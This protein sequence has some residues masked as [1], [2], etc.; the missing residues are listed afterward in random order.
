MITLSIT[1]FILWL[2]LVA[3]AAGS[4]TF[5]AAALFACAARDDDP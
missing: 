3:M 1:W 5:V 4:I 2:L